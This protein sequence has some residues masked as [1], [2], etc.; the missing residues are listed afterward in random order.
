MNV[1]QKLSH[2]PAAAI[3]L[4]LHLFFQSCSN[5]TNPANPTNPR[6]LHTEKSIG[7]MLESSQ[8]IVINEL[9]NQKFTASGGY[10]LTFHENN[11][12]LQADV[13]L[14]EEQKTANYRNLPVTIEAEVDLKKLTY[15]HRKIQE[16]RIEVG[17]FQNGQPRRIFILQSGLLGGMKRKR[18][19][20]ENEKDQMEQEEEEKKEKNEGKVKEIRNRQPAPKKKKKH[21]K[22]NIIGN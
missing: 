19:D 3:L 15:Q 13:W 22:G 8:Q 21:K 11:G 4:G 2:R 12:E 18:G 7:V 20:M 5:Y 1:N 14:D 16:R 9:P 17:C 10:T 6:G